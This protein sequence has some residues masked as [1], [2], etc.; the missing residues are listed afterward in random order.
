MRFA[1]TDDQ[2][3]FRDAL[4]DLLTR[5]CPPSVVRDAWTSEAGRTKGLWSQL[6]EMGITGALVSEGAGGLGLGPI[7]L[8]LLLEECGY[9]AVP[10]PV[11]EHAVVAAPLVPYAA[12]VLNGSLCVTAQ[13]P[14]ESTV[15]YGKSADFLLLHHDERFH[16]V[17]PSDVKLTERASVDGSR[18]LADVDWEPST[19]AAVGSAHETA[20]ALDRGAL[21]TAAQLIGLARR[22]LD[23]SVDYVSER[24]Q[25]GAPVGSFQAVKHHLAD[26]RIALEFARP[27]VY[28]AAWSM[29]E[30]DPDA[31]THVSM[32]KSTAGDAA[33][34][35]AR[36]ALQC[37]G[38]IGYSFE[39]DLHLF[40]KRAWALASSWGDGPWHRARVGRAIL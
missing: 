29:T 26:A 38:A 12:G 16:L 40:M 32:A 28:R 13:C 30:H 39:Y 5:E 15:A 21:G 6:G 25:F 14:L 37:H 31:P 18:R 2:V 27:L 8:V 24:R 23:M 3:A 10:E 11:M 19:D 22:M 4:R 34:L 36:K 17:G 35:T 7:D 9:A 33:A 20:L 1:F